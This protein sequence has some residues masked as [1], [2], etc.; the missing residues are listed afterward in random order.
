MEL[1]D[2]ILADTGKNLNISG[3]LGNTLDSAIIIHKN[4]DFNKHTEAEDFIL[5]Y[6]EKGRKLN[7]RVVDRSLVSHKDKKIN[8]IKVRI[9]SESSKEAPIYV[10]AYYFDVTEWE[11]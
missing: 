2:A 7:W 1:K 8:K 9:Q 3:G 6:Y 5:N 11:S 4:S 10:E